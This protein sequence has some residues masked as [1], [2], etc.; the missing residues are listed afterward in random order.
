M[1][2]KNTV[3][4]NFTLGDISLNRNPEF[5]YTL[6]VPDRASTAIPLFDQPDLKAA[7]RLKMDIPETWDGI[8][9]GPLENTQVRDGRKILQFGLTKPFSTYVF[10]FTA[11]KFQRKTAIRNGREMHMLYRE[12]DA[13][14]VALNADEIFD[15]HAA[16]IDWMEVY[17]GIK[18]PFQK[19]DFALIPGFQYG[20]MEHI[21]AIFYRESSLFL[22]EDATPNQKLGRASLIAHETSHM[23]FGDMVTMR[24]F[25]DVWLKEV[26]ANFIAAKIVNPA[27][28]E[29]NHD[30]RFV[31][32]H[33]PAAYSEDRSEGAH[34]VQQDLDNLKNAGTL[35]GRIIYQKAPI[36]M[37]QLETLIGED[38]LRSGLQE[39]LQTF[40]YDNATWDDLIEILDKRTSIDL[41]SW[42]Q[43]WVKEAGMPVYRTQYIIDK[44]L[45]KEASIQQ[46]KQSASGRYWNQLTDLVLFYPDT[47]M[48]FQVNLNG[49]NT[50]VNAIEGYPKPLAI[51]SNG[52]PMSYGYHQLDRESQEYLLANLSTIKDPLLRGAALMALEESMLNGALTPAQL[53]DCVLNSL[54]LETEPLN[55]QRLLGL[56]SSLFWRYTLPENR[57]LFA[58]RL[59]DLL[60][61][62]LS[63][64][65]DPGAKSAYWSTFVNIVT[66]DAAVDKL[67]S[68]WNGAQA[69]FDLS[70]TEGRLSSLGHALALRLPSQAESILDELAQRIKNPDRLRRLAFVRPAL[71]SNQADRDAF[72][73]SLKSAENRAVEPWVGEAL[74]Y[75]HHP[76]RAE[77]SLVY[78][79]PSLELMEEIQATGDIFFPRQWISAT[80]S[81]HQSPEAAQIVRDFLA[82]NPD[83]SYRLKNK[84]LMA[85][86]PLFRSAQLLSLQ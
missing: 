74:R 13:E 40:A 76:L 7:Y 16:S 84:V 68:V 67:L 60:W 51:I 27:F 36:V 35:Y 12:S 39:Y 73:N 33:Q 79:K 49:A 22:E 26:F 37:R 81:G 47:I 44:G 4:L 17:S 5:L 41:K 69:N 25:N 6:F 52:A 43:V 50:P 24:W 57:S 77:M 65:K 38:S 85:A 46:E 48:R 78:I 55:R 18:M 32:A 66:S 15:L 45:I 23:W 31:F 53:M 3:D 58:S 2:G 14:K 56:S 59:E 30:L 28:P 42:S 29:I 9:N 34:P 86:D 63:N 1:S 54:Q 21:G 71:A 72:F 8:A 64:S 20:G 11:G 61:D 70:L 10:A 75:L 80:L 62:K 19:F 83:F 82:E